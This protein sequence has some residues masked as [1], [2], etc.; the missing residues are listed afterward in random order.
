MSVG[1]TLSAG[2]MRLGFIGVGWIGLNRLRALAASGTA[3]VS[4]VC[5]PSDEAMTRVREIAPHAHRAANIASLLDQDLD[6]LV[7]ATPNA[8]HAEQAIAALERGIAVFCQKPLARTEAE[9]RRVIDAARSN[10]RLLGVDLSYRH[11]DGMRRIRDLV[12]LG[13]FGR[14][15]AI[16]LVFHNAYGPDKPWFRDFSSSGG[17]CV[18]DLGIH[19][20]D[21]LLWMLDDDV[22]QVHA[23]LYAQGQLLASAPNTVEDDAMVQLHLTSGATA[24]LRCSWYAHAG[25]DAVIGVSV[26]GTAGGADWHNV[27]GSFHDFA[28]ERHHRTTSE[29]LSSPPDDWGGRAALAWLDALAAGG[30]YDPGIQSLGRVAATLDAIYGRSGA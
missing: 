26:R 29:L 5:D 28:A 12:R 30:R 6:G 16:E 23:R 14:V 9:T 18:L 15:H 2:T 10:D 21:L 20:I 11:T 3:E 8:M 17:G 24:T 22:S 27:D 13:A 19:L 4:S 1:A 25:R 7:I